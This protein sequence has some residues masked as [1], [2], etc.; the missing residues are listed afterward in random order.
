MQLL[1]QERR[2]PGHNDNAP[3]SLRQYGI[4]PPK[5]NGEGDYSTWWSDL[6]AYF[7]AFPE[8]ADEQKIRILG[9]CISGS[10][11]MILDAAG[12]LTTVVAADH[13]LRKVFAVPVNWTAKLWETVQMTNENVSHFYARLRL[14][15]IKSMSSNV[16]LSLTNIDE[17]CLFY[18]RRNTRP[19]ISQRLSWVMPS[20]IDAALSIALNVEQ[21]ESESGSKV[22]PKKVLKTDSICLIESEEARKQDLDYQNRFRQ[23]NDKLNS[24]TSTVNNLKYATA[25]E[26]KILNE[27]S[28]QTIVSSLKNLKDTL[29][30]NDKNYSNIRTQS[31]RNRGTHHYKCYHCQKPGHSYRYCYAATEEQKT[32]IKNKFSLNQHRATSNSRK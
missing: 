21:E 9:S 10:A 20:T 13:A 27:Q 17:A 11:R 3:P 5:F 14:I 23:L 16:N 22:K 6:H 26:T 15:V 24:L 28:I 25:Q 32:A 31:N 19:E 18:F 30:E 7:G 12:P 29:S 2:I 1:Q 4:F 8:M